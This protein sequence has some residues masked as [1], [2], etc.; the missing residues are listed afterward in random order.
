MTSASPRRGLGLS[1]WLL[2]IL[3][4]LLA[5]AAG[6]TWALARFD[7]VARFVGVTGDPTPPPATTGLAPQ[8][9]AAG[10]FS[11]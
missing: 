4:L 10:P 2:L 6:A 5:G 7:G 8:A 3:V 9:L 1:A 11:T